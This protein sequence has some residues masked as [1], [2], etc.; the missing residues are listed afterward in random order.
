MMRA[1]LTLSFSLGLAAAMSV[2]S[3][4]ALAGPVRSTPGGAVRALP[5]QIEA[6]YRQSLRSLHKAA[7]KQRALDG[8]ELTP[9]HLAE[10]QARLDRVNDSYRRA[11]NNNNPLS[12]DSNG[13]A[14]NPKAVPADWTNAPVMTIGHSS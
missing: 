3:T 9:V 12:V 8:G 2:A 4:G 14:V 1:A 7:L 6:G 11:L 10:F 13:H 5:I